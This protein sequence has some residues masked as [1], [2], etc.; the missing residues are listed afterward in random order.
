MVGEAAR[1]GHQEIIKLLLAN[2]TISENARGEAVR[3]AARNGHREITELL[4]SGRRN[5]LYR[6]KK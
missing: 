3:A 4:F 6:T 1:N 2:G 5:F